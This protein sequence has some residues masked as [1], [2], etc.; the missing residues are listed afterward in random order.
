[1]NKENQNWQQIVTDLLK[2]KTQ[3]ALA[4]EIGT[5]QARIW[6]WKSGKH[7]PTGLYKKVLLEMWNKV[8]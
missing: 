5:K 6:E 3:R 1:M 7:S 4:E 2:T 8:K